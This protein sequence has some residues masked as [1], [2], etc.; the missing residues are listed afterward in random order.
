MHGKS[1]LREYK[2]IRESDLERVAKEVLDEF[3][4]IRIIAFYGQ[5]GAGKTTL[6]K[7]FCRQLGVTNGMSSPTFSLI[8]EYRN[9]DGERMYHFDFYRIKS[10]LEAI[11]IG[12][13]EYFYS[14]CYCFVEWPENVARLLP[15]KYLEIRILPED[16]KHRTIEVKQHG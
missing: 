4:D 12:T 6:I 7:T 14:G 9:R 11:D 1:R 2:S 15:E 8:N 10:E 16:Q 13:E 3:P 5:M